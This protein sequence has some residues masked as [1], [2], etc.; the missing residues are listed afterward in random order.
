M[1]GCLFLQG[2]HLCS[3]TWSAGELADIPVDGLRKAFLMN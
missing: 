2:K 1:N 3:A